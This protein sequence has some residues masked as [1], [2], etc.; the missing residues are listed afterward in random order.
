MH[1]MNV[2]ILYMRHV[3]CVARSHCSRL[4]PAKAQPVDRMLKI[5]FRFQRCAKP[6]HRLNSQSIPSGLGWTRS[7]TGEVAAL[8]L[9]LFIWHFESDGPRAASPDERVIETWNFKLLV[10]LIGYCN[11][12][13]GN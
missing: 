5:R 6:Y 3:Y 4:S 13:K 11:Q 12:D 1:N 9:L 8:E 10:I 2:T 7:S